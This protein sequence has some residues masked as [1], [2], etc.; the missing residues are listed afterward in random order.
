MG[1]HIMSLADYG[2]VGGEASGL[3]IPPHS[4]EAEQSVLGGLLLDNGAWHRAGD[5]LTESDFYRFEHRLI[6]AAIGAL[7]NATKPADVITVFEQLQSLGKADECG[8]LVYL[9]ALAQ[10]VPS[11]ANMRPYAEIVRERAVLRKLVAASDEIATSAFNPQGRSV[12]EILD[13]AN[14]KMTAAAASAA[15]PPALFRSVDLSHLG[16]LA[17][18]HQEWFWDGRIPAGHLTHLGGH[19]GA[20]KS[21]L[22][23]M[24]G[25]CVAT[26]NECL[27]RPTKRARVLYFS[28]EDPE[29]LVLRRLDRVCRVLD[30]DHQHVREQL[31]VIDATEFDPVLFYERRIDGMRAGSTTPTYA[32]LAKYVERH[33]IEF[34][35][36]DNA[37]D[38][39]EADEINRALVRA[40]IRTLVQLVRPRNGSVLLLAH[41]DK[42]TSRAGKSQIN[43]E[44]YSGSTAWHNSARSRLFLL[45]KESG[46]F[47]LQH[48]K[49]NLGAKQEPLVLEWPAEGLLQVV[50]GTTGRG[51]FVQSIND[52]TDTR[53][54]LALIHEFFG[55]G[56]YVGTAQQSRHHAAALLSGEKAYPKRKA[57]EVFG[58]LRDAERKRLICRDTYKDSN[59]KQ[60]ERWALTPEGLEFV[61]AAPCAPCAPTSDDGAEDADGA[62]RVRH[63]RHVRSGGYRGSEQRTLEAPKGEAL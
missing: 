54:L 20:G 5:L 22:G 33:E 4:V 17:P 53:A 62:N 49:C 6:F 36:I 11:A 8:G 16:E 43:T 45:E 46:A 34:L 42:G 28:G 1:D 35:I 41:V 25:S 2:G 23:L 47:E 56:E 57:A 26:G 18:S 61:G 31:H 9:N 32:A 59:R 13:E 55:R 37:S 12:S 7:V 63:V 21:T 3:R 24:I 44:A 40:F 10:S 58:L 30:L 19:G 29:E 60:H 27:G 14:A 39:Y 52:T 48:Q 50:G 51:G 15:P 38:A